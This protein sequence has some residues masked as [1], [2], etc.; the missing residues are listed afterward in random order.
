MG[1]RAAVRHWWIGSSEPQGI[2]RWAGIRESGRKGLV[3]AVVRCGAVRL[4]QTGGNRIPKLQPI[5]KQQNSNL[6]GTKLEKVN[7]GEADT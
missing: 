2:G 7:V 3:G 5:G 6:K 4:Q 1:G